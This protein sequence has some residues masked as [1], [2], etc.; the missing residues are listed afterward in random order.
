[1][2]QLEPGMMIWTWVTFIVLFIILAKVAWKPILSA[3]EQRENQIKDSMKKA[4]EARA[5]AEE[6][7]EKQQKMMTEAQEEIQRTLKENKDVAEKM[8]NEIL[9]QARIEAQKIQQRAQESI[10]REKE[11]AILELKKQVADIALQVASRLIQENLD[12][13]KH[14]ELINNYIKD[15]D[16]LEK[17]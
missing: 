14:R 15:L 10:E 16:R 17:N 2:L 3:V 12:S 9:E 1:M 11:A 8:K 5:E 4:Q 13:K 7:L 6:L